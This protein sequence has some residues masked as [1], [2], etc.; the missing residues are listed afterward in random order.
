MAEKSV[1]HASGDLQ[2]LHGWVEKPEKGAR[3]FKAALIIGGIA[4]AMPLL[5]WLIGGTEYV[6]HAFDG[7]PLWS[8]NPAYLLLMFL[9]VAFMP[10]VVSHSVT[11]KGWKRTIAAMV[12]V[13]LV[14]STAEFLGSNYGYIFGPYHYSNVW[15]FHVLGVPIVVPIAWETLL[16]PSFYLSLYLMPTELFGKART[17]KQKIVAN[18]LLALTGA[19]I[20]VAVDMLLDPI[21]AGIGSW[22]WHVNGTYVD[23]LLGGEPIM[24]WIGWM[25]VGVLIMTAYRIIL[26]STPGKMHVRSRYLDVYIPM[27]V[28]SSFFIALMEV[29]IIFQRHTDV[30]LLGAL[31]FG[32]VVT[33]VW[34]KL[35]HEKIGGRPNV[36]G[37]GIA[38]EALAQ[39]S[40]TVRI[41]EEV[42][43]K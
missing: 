43:A 31:S 21:C 2:P 29:A 14:T 40:A 34:S 28:Y 1:S 5:M 27:V 37:V 15:N 16:I 35:Y 33:M 9:F 3:I 22:N 13:Y 20:V 24:N 36:I 7:T 30:A 8:G 4:V 32:I 11:V 41:A 18:G 10:I 25:L 17:L 12:A 39:Q 23:W 26:G 6:T 42:L 38:E 19:V